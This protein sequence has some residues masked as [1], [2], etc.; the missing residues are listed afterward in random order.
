MN[1]Q[2]VCY[3]IQFFTVVH[4]HSLYEYLQPFL[5]VLHWLQNVYLSWVIDL[6]IFQ[7]MYYHALKMTAFSLIYCLF[8]YIILLL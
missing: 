1:H 7:I 2:L 5:E 3:N 6:G 8:Y 4:F